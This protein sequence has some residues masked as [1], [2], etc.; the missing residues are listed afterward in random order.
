MRLL[1]H[2][3]LTEAGFSILADRKK[4]LFGEPSPIAAPGQLDPSRR[5]QA[6]TPAAQLDPS[7][8]EQA[9][10]AHREPGHTPTD[11]VPGQESGPKP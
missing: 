11:Q 1:K 4:G 7:P 2:Y 5:E 9:S 3:V 8:R 10:P 6:A